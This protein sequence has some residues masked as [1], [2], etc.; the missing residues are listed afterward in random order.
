[1]AHAGLVW[2][3][4]A[5]G[6]LLACVWSHGGVLTCPLLFPPG[7]IPTIPQ[8]PSCPQ[9]GV[10]SLVATCPLLEPSPPV[11]SWSCPRL[12]PPG[13]APACPRQ[14]PSLPAG[15]VPGAL[16]LSLSMLTA[17]LPGGHAWSSDSP[18]G[19]GPAPRKHVE[20]WE[21]PQEEELPTD[22]GSEAGFWP[23]EAALPRPGRGRAGT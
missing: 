7:A 5:A 18:G 17:E 1:M 6:S 13:A 14:Q 15:I 2:H 12:S 21:T 20:G 16:S 3:G 4:Q 23:Q 8:V 22:L 9:L 11:P 10:F 19:G